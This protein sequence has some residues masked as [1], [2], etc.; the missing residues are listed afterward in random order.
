MKIVNGVNPDY[1][2]FDEIDVDALD[3][4]DEFDR[5]MVTLDELRQLI[6][7]EA[8]R[9]RAQLRYEDPESLFDDP[10]QF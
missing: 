2:D 8:A 7:P 4:L 3:A 6:G 5:G 1:A 9:A 10:E